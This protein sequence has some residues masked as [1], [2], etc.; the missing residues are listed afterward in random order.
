M[1]VKNDDNAAAKQG[2]LSINKI[3][4]TMPPDLSCAVSANMQSQFFQSS[5]YSPGTP[6]ICIWNTGS[7]YVDPKNS[8]L[9]FDVTNTSTA[10]AYFGPAYGGSALNLIRQFTLYS[11]SGTIIERIDRVNQLSAIRNN[12]ER[13][14]AWVDTVGSDGHGSD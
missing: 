4:Y 2:I 9:C 14:Q 3:S 1:E 6:A 13:S 7:Q 12:F 10:G 11:R 8:I 5:T